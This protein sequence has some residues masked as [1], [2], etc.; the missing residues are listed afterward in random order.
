MPST[1]TT[2]KNMPDPKIH[3]PRI[4]LISGII[5]IVVT[6]LAG[7]TVFVVMQRHTEAL[8]SKSLQLSLQSRVQLTRA[9]IG[10]GFDKT[11]LISTRPLLVD[12][13]QLV[14]ASADGTAARNKLD[15]GARSFLQTGLTA[16]ALYGKDGQ[17]LARAGVF[18]QQPELA[19]P[20]NFPGHVQLMWDG[21]LL[22][23]AVVEIKKEGRV[24]G[25]VMTESSLPVIMGAIKDARLLGETGELALCAPFGLK[26]QCFPTALNPKI[27]TPPQRSPQ[28]VRLPMTHAFEGDT[29]FVITK[30]YHHQEVVAAYAPVG[31][32]GLGMVLKMDKAELFA[33]VWQ[34]LRFLI[35]LLLGVLVIALLLPRWGLTPL[36]L[37]LVRAEAQAHELSASL[38]ASE[39]HGQAMLDNVHEGIVSISETGMIELFNPA[40]ERLFGYRSEEVVGKNVSMLMPE[41][42]H[43]EHDGHLARYLRTGQTK[44]IGTGREVTGRRSDG[45]V[46]PMYLGVSEFSLEERRQF[47]G[48]IRD[49]TELKRIDRMKTE[50]VSTV[51]HELRTPLTSIRGSLGLIAGGVAGELPEAVKSLVGIA[52]NN[53]ERLIR[54]I[55]D[56][57]DI[58]KIESGE[59]RLNLQVVDIKQLVQ[60]VLA[61]NES[62]AGQHRVTV[63]LRVPDEPLQVRIDSDRLT[64][65]LTNLLS[66]AEKFSPPESTVE[67]RVSRVAQQVRVEVADHGPGIPEEFRSRIFQK[68]S[69]ADSSDSR[70]KGGTGLGL[71]ISK[72]LVEQMNGAIGFNSQVGAGTTFFFE[73]PE[74]KE[75]AI[76]PPPLR[77]QAAASS[78]PGSKPRILHVE[79][80]PDIQ[81][82]VAAIAGDVANFEFAATLDQARARLREQRF[83][84]VLLDPALGQDSGWYLFKDIDALDPRPPVIVFSARDVDP[85]DRKQVEAVLVKART[86]N[87]ELL[88]TIQRVLQISGDPGPTRPQ[89]PS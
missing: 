35:P 49:I 52:K 71:N 44:I 89:T 53:C 73:L 31:D 77:V 84:L 20:L 54:L 75:P 40:A 14:D 70:Q 22:L 11:V 76:L 64:Q 56:M 51:S 5:L 8:L 15:M 27:F 17:E 41:P 72:A 34:Q 19:V 61:A 42:Y 1:D 48:C 21:Q 67:V 3:Q 18:A 23:R 74:W 55:N 39:R 69:Q 29:G 66:N 36:V 86:S 28:G 81:R 38:R 85:A 58:E 24:V 80:E 82:I 25:K 30:D 26:M 63:L 43:S 68:F 50:F 59:M 45:S 79:D 13:L 33:P 83:D 4:V 65:V 88:H 46:F 7:V 78:R 32:L 16:I 37:G 60:Q 87:A 2:L 62:L 47:I 12:Q 6:L 10:A 57:L 9:E